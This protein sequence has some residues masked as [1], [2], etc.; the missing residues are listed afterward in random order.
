MENE[1][2]GNG[3]MENIFYAALALHVAGKP[4]NKE[5]IRVVLRAAGTPVDEPA[6]DIIGAFIESLK[7]SHGKNDSCNDSRI[8]KL[9]TTVLSQQNGPTEQL[10]TLL[11]D[12]NKAAVISQ[13]KG[14]YVYGITAGGKEV[15]LGPIGI[16][17]SEVYTIAYQDLGAIVHNCPTEPY[18]SSDDETVKG[19]VKTH[20]SVLD[21]AKEQFKIIIPLGFDTILKSGR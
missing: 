10:E 18:Q 1:N 2:S 19:W 16:D 5:N 4:I 21:T 3:K 13:N 6:L 17:G 14:R 7:V 12:L 11:G 8:I 20:Q 9:L 15:K